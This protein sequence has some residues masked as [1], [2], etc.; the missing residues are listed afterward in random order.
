[1]K[2]AEVWIFFVEISLVS[3]PLLDFLNF[4]YILFSMGIHPLYCVRLTFNSRNKIK[5]R[6]MDLTYI[7]VKAK[8]P[9]GNALHRYYLVQ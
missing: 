8:S 6:D 2:T 5:S 4:V 9:I 1:M 3:F 7:N